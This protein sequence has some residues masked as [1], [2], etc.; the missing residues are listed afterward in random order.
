MP[1]LWTM[2]WDGKHVGGGV[3]VDKLGARRHPGDSA[4]A[5]SATSDNGC[6]RI[7]LPCNA[8]D[9]L[10]TDLVRRA[11]LRWAGDAFRC[12]TVSQAVVFSLFRIVCF[13][14]FVR[15]VSLLRSHSRLCYRVQ[16]LLHGQT[17]HSSEKTADALDLVRYRT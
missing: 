2:N 3:T 16:Q 17:R 9:A 12:Q 14:L 1:F 15:S 8:F 5:T 4:V 7:R 13:H 11:T 6:Q 10:K